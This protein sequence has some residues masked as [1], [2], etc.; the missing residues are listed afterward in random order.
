MSLAELDVLE[1]IFL[2]HHDNHAILTHADF[3]VDRFLPQSPV[4][5][6]SLH[7][8]TKQEELVRFSW[9]ILSK[10]KYCNWI[11]LYHLAPKNHASIHEPLYYNKTLLSHIICWSIY[12]KHPIFSMYNILWKLNFR[13]ISLDLIDSFSESLYISLYYYKNMLDIRQCTWFSW[14]C[15]LPKMLNIIHNQMQ[16]MYIHN[17]PIVCI[18]H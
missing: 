18:K 11:H 15:Y 7:K 17:R 5:H 13:L 12:C 2:W 8:T 16:Y 1:L 9:S 14:S 10:S 6:G 3:K 4:N